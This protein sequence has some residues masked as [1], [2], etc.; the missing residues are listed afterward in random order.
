MSEDKNSSVFLHPK[1]SYLNNLIE[2]LFP[3]GKKFYVVSLFSLHPFQNIITFLFW[4][5]IFSFDF[6]IITLFCMYRLLFLYLLSRFFC[7]VLSSSSLTVMCLHMALFFFLWFV[8]Y[9]E[10]QFFGFMDFISFVNFLDFTWLLL[11]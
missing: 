4:I 11:L 10:S 6:N 8:T 1:V 5:A 7:T 2:E 9:K 3:L